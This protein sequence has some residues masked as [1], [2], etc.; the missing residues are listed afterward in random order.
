MSWP[1]WGS[2]AARSIIAWPMVHRGT[3]VG[4]P[5]RA[6]K[7]FRPLRFFA[8]TSDAEAMAMGDRL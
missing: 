3:Q 8:F 5:D 2:Q 1:D 6:V 7:R 4:W